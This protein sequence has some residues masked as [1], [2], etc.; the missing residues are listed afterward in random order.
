MIISKRLVKYTGTSIQ[1][2]IMQLLKKKSKAAL[3]VY[4][5]T[6]FQNDAIK[7]KTQ[8]AQ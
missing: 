2:N 6:D 1:L 4:V 8:D 7:C 3:C 5:W